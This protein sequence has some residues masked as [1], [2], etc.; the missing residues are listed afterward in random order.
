MNFANKLTLSRIG[1][2]FIF[3][4]FLFLHWPYAKLCA[5]FIFLAASFTDYYDGKI[6]KKRNQ[7]TDFGKLM[8]PIADKILVLAAFLAFVELKIIPAWM[9]VIII[10]RELIITGM[11]LT[12]LSK[13]KVVPA[14]KAG[15][16]KTVSQMS[17]IFVILIYLTIK[18]LGESIFKF[19]WWDANVDYNIHLAIYVMMLMTVVLTLTSGISYLKDNVRALK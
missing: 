18:Q 11:R 3:M 12:L 9:V 13:K 19:A 17:S 7:V 2:A 4:L 15:K 8:D 6:A 1:L 16:H 14:K 10:F 5:L